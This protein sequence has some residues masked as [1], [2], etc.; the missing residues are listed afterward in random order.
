MRWAF[1]FCLY[2]LE[3][4]FYSLIFLAPVQQD[5]TLLAQIRLA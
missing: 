5:V 2:N 3:L 1:S 4:N